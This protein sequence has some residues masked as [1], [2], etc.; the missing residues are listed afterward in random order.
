MQKCYFI[1]AY[2]C[3]VNFNINIHLNSFLLTGHTLSLLEGTGNNFYRKQDYLRYSCK[4]LLICNSVDKQHTST[5]DRLLS[6]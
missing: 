1:F 5:V 4:Q 3:N 6:R 2:D